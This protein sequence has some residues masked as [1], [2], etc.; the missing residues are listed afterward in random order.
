MVSGRVYLVDKQ[1]LALLREDRFTRNASGVSANQLRAL[2]SP[3]FAP[4]VLPVTQRQFLAL[5]MFCARCEFT[6]PLNEAIMWGDI[7]TCPQCQEPYWTEEF[8]LAFRV[9]LAQQ[10][11]LALAVL[12]EYQGELKRWGERYG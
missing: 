7:P 9:L 12:E 10:W 4:H 6:M 3:R 11:Q 2:A 8:A 5:P 1:Y